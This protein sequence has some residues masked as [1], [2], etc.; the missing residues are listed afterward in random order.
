MT[1]GAASAGAER[2]HDVAHPP[3]LVA[4]RV[5]HAQAGEARDEDAGHG[6]HVDRLAR[7]AH[8]GVRAQRVPR[9]RFGRPLRCHGCQVRVVAGVGA[10]AAAPDASSYPP[11]PSSRGSCG[12]SA[13]TVASAAQRPTT[14]PA[15]ALSRAAFSALVA[16]S[17]RGSC[18]VSGSARA[19]D[20]QQPAAGVLAAQDEDHLLR[21][22]RERLLARAA[23]DVRRALHPHVPGG[24]GAVAG[25]VDPQQAG[26]V[27]R[28]RQQRGLLVGRGRRRR[29]SARSRR[30]A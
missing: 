23:D 28:L 17:H 21:Q 22:G 2:D 20:P 13:V 25:D 8:R 24:P 12:T 15:G 16:G 30:R 3:D 10:G 26:L 6:V 29:V 27:R 1:R 18:G 5:E 11:G 9:R 4:E 19:G 14:S 7:R